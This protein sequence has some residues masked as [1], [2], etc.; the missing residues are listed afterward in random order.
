MQ[1]RTSDGSLGYLD[2]I[3]YRPQFDNPNA[4]D[5]WD[6]DALPYNS[7]AEGIVFDGANIWVTVHTVNDKNFV[8]KR[9]AS[10]GTWL[11]EFPV[12]HQ[13][14]GVVFDGANIWVANSLD[15]TLTKLRA[16]DGT[17]LGTFATG[18]HPT[19]LVFDGTHIWVTNGGGNTVSR[20]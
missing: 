8:C 18:V 14:I 5:Y 6:N 4:P 9:R 1:R 3:T 10:D 2:S 20:F 12:G 17:N 15:N 19:W 7:E 16:S 11:G 13:P